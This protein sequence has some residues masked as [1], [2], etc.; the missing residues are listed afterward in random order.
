LL[1]CVIFTVF[2]QSDEDFDIEQNRQGG[3]TITKY[4]G[5]LKSVVIPSTISGLKVTEI[6]L[7]AFFDKGIDEVIIPNTIQII[8]LHAFENNN[9]KS[10]NLPNGLQKIKSEAFRNNKIESLIIPNTV[11]EIGDLCFA[12]NNITSVTLPNNIHDYNQGVFSNNPL[13]T[14][15]LGGIKNIFDYAFRETS[16]IISITIGRNVYIDV[17]TYIDS[18]FENVYISN[19]KQAGTYIKTGR[20]WIKQ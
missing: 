4:L 3:I 9:L 10:L 18:S 13:T 11:I 17:H 7:N 5:S 6:G 16:N 2:P 1:F 12:N 20:I 14:I 15:N 19:G 8:E